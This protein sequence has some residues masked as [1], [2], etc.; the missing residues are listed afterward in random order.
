MGPLEILNF[1]QENWK[2][3]YLAEKDFQFS[4]L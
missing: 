1:W 2:K 4:Q 3:K